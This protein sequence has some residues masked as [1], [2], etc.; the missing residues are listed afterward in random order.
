MEQLTRFVLRHKR[1]VAAAW[2]ALTLVGMVAAGPASEALDQKFSVPGREG[3]DTSQQILKVYGNGGESLPLVP[4]VQLPQGT[5]VES[6]GVREQL[7]AVEEAAQKA[8][9]RSRIAGFGSTG[10][11]AFVSQDGRTTF[12]YV[13]P[14]RSDDPFGGNAKLARR[15]EASLGRLQVGGAPVKVSGYDALA[16]ASGDTD[17][18]GVLLEA[19]IGGLG[20]L[21]VL[22]FVFGSALAFV[23]I[24]MAI[25][26]VLVSFLLLWGLTAVTDVSPI[27]QFLVALIGLG[28]SIDYALLIVVRWRE[29]REKGLGNDDAVAA[30]MATAGRAVVFSGTTVAVGLLALIVLPLPFLRSMGYGG[31]L[32]PLVATA[33]AITLLPVI[34]AT[35]GPRLDRRRIRRRDR[36]EHFWQRWSEG[37]VRR[38]GAAAALAVGILLVLVFAASGLHLGN[39]DPDTIA[40][41]GS[42]KEGLVA[43]DASGIGKGAIAPTETLVPERDAAAVAQAQGKVE[44]VHGAV[45]PEGEGWRRD[46]MAIVAAMPRQGDESSAGRDTV[47]GLIDAG[48]AGSPDARVGGSGPLNR[49]F[50]HA[51]YGAFPLMI[52]LIS[53]LTFLLLARAFR[54]LLLPAKAVV[55]NILSVA[56]AWGVIAWFWQEGHGSDAIWGISA[57]GSIAAWVPLMIFAFLYGLSMDYEVFILARMREEY[58]ITGDTDEAVVFG[59]GRTGRLVTSAALILFLTFAAMASGPQTDVKILA[60]GLAAG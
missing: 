15:L 35:I 46:G 42:A 5:T 41:S 10:D 14:P 36:S 30:A 4:V 52:A 21:L 57:T 9:P 31:M 33:V 6:A 49:D 7:R 60:T 3:W 38:R 23:P 32:I 11:K 19:V 37:V 48:H 2:V 16:D 24:A 34:L 13:F 40:K 12:V 28:V 22:F 59:L 44:G 43:L 58:D 50:I 27:V 47:K 53:V 51:V 26:S 25:S 54:S 8:S 29:E 17:G 39:A 20:A 1:L 56:A 55:L 18:P 45:A